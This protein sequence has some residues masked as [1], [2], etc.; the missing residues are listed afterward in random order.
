MTGVDTVML[1]DERTDPRVQQQT[2]FVQVGMENFPRRR[3]AVMSWS[4]TTAS[5]QSL[6][7]IEEPAPELQHRLDASA[8]HSG[9]RPPSQIVHLRRLRRLASMCI[10]WLIGVDG[11][12]SG[13]RGSGAAAF[14]GCRWTPL[15]DRIIREV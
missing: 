2:L 12:E 6:R 3:I 8:D 4:G 10:A 15:G 13:D 1:L 11:Q 5:I 9:P 7:H 14:N